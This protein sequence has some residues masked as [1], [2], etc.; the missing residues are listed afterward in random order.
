MNLDDLEDLAGK[1]R[2]ETADVETEVRVCMAASC[3]SSGAEPVM[4]ALTDACADGASA[5]EAA[6]AKPVDIATGV[7]SCPGFH[8]YC[9]GKAD[10]ADE[11]PPWDDGSTGEDDLQPAG[12]AAGSGSGAGAAAL[13]L[14]LVGLAATRRRR[15]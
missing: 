10:G 7:P 1:F 15:A 3:Q 4:K 13:I 2:A 8:L 14:L 6:P 12:C 11:P 5:L 9:F